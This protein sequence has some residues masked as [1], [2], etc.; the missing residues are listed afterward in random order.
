MVGSLDR[1]YFGLYVVRASLKINLH[2]GLLIYGYPGVK[3]VTC[4][5]VH[6]QITE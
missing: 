3:F 4:T 2:F 1:V 5:P 6:V